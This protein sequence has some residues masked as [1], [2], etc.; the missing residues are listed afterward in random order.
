MQRINR[1]PSVLNAC[2][3]LVIIAATV[4]ALLGV[5]L[6]PTASSKQYILE[7]NV[8][9]INL[10]KVFPPDSGDVVDQY[11]FANSGLSPIYR[12]GFTGYCAGDITDG[13]FHADHCKSMGSHDILNL[14]MILKNEVNVSMMDRS[15]ISESQIDLPDGVPTQRTTRHRANQMYGGIM[16]AMG[17]STANL[18]LW[19][20]MHTAVYGLI[21]WTAK[22]TKEGTPKRTGLVIALIVGLIVISLLRFGASAAWLAIAIGGGIGM[23]HVKNIVSA[24]NDG[25]SDYGITAKT[26]TTSF[27]LMFGS[28]GA[29]IL[30]CL[31]WFRVQECN[32]VTIVDDDV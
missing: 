28:M 9:S 17:L 5:F 4:M 25:V 22:P 16:A 11:S 31:I 3:T 19:F 24:L 12:V 14:E 20:L 1:G 8:T 32:K 23:N 7:V 21:V 27:G 30:F 6:T 26:G 18:V 15:H 10:E 2:L 13:A 29:T